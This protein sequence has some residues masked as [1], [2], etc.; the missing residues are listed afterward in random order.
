MNLSHILENAAAFDPDRAAI[1]HAGGTTTFA[2]LAARVRRLSGGLRR[3]AGAAR[4][5]RIAIL[6]HN[7]PDTIATLFAAAR[8]GAMAVPLNWRLAVPELAAILADCRPAALLVEARFAGI[9]PD[10]AAAAAGA[11]IVALPGEAVEG[12][13]PFEALLE[14]P[15][16]DPLAEAGRLPVLL[17]YT[18]G[19]TGRA[20]GA[21]LSQDALAWNAFHAVHLHDMTAADHVLTVLPLFHVGGLNI[22][23]TPALLTGA[24][25]TL[26]S[27]FD[28]E[29]TLAAIAT[30]R[31]TLTVLVPATLKALLAAPGFAA[32]DLGSLRAITTGST[33]V[34]PALK[35]A[36]DARGVPVLEVYGATETA[37]IAVHTRLSGPRAPE[38]SAGRPALAA[39]VRIL[40]DDGTEVAD[41]TAGEI[42]VRGPF[43]ADG[44]FG[45]P[46]ETAAAFR[47]G[48]FLTGDVATRTADGWLVVHDRKKNMLVSGGE[49][50]FPAEIERVLA[51]HPA[52]AEC[53][54]V[55]RPDSRWDEVPVAF[56]V[57]RPGAHVDAATLLA[58]LSE[59]IAR[60]KVPREIRFLDDLPR[61]ALGKVQHFRLKALVEGRFS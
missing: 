47:D 59:R 55:G 60:F 6:A 43:V 34:P 8:V 53:A 24:T 39:E 40:A 2:A 3:L 38:G 30:D 5:E 33:I 52:V 25:V 7:H 45:R 37:P 23:T 58:H 15:P 54:V 1:R 14:G 29:A 26:H 28:P 11:R 35:R 50:V 46:E 51:A 31:P 9:L 18:S 4:G 61:N 12:A 57:A 20:R 21:L 48:F 27:R 19:T 32:A 10:L 36:F 41:G 22:Q 56:V 44:Y 42:A 17:S 13:L 49:N 16:A